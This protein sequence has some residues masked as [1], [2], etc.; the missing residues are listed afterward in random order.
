[1]PPDI[2]LR[3]L[4]ETD[5]PVLF[6]QQRDPVAVRMAAFVS[7][8]P[9][10]RAA[11]DAHWSRILAN[12]TGPNFAVLDRDRVVGSVS[13][14]RD[15]FGPEV[16]YWIAREHWGRGVATAA[17]RALLDGFPERPLHG[18]AAADNAASLRVLEKCGFVRCG[19]ERGFADARGEEITEV[20]MVLEDGGTR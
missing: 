2:T 20:V 15:R 9:E 4:T 17:L 1:M 8:D 12:P 16:T 3:E 10:D 5:L 18:R 11:F 14:Y 13:V 6:E 19:E 7:R